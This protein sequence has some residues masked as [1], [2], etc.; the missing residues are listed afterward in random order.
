MDKNASCATDVYLGLRAGHD[1]DD[2]NL[3][4]SIHAS[5][6]CIHKISG[7]HLKWLGDTSAKSPGA[8]L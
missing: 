3:C 2:K 5:V 1:S 8:V 4:P 6:S 7:D